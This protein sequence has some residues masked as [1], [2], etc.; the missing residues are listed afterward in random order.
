MSPFV[1]KLLIFCAEKEIVVER[2]S[3]GISFTDEG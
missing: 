2:Q 1:R 3:V